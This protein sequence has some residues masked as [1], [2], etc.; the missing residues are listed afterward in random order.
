MESAGSIP[1]FP[2]Q[3]DNG[4]R[5]FGKDRANGSRSKDFVDA[6]NISVPNASDP[7]E[8]DK[9]KEKESLNEEILDEDI[10]F[11]R[12]EMRSSAR[13]K[14]HSKSNPVKEV[15]ANFAEIMRTI[16]D[17]TKES[18]KIF[19]K[20]KYADDDVSGVHNLERC[21]QTCD[22]HAACDFGAQASR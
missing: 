10:S 19:K 14:K 8:K 6:A 7:K 21:F 2:S 5:I 16:I 12:E 15:D 20:P 1:S 17:L 13:S 3:S 9:W 22:L 11:V 18:L 4:F